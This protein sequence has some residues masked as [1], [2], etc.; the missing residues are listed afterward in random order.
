VGRT[1]LERPE[2]GGTAGLNL[3]ASILGIPGVAGAIQPYATRSV[4]LRL[5]YVRRTENPRKIASSGVGSSEESLGMG[6]HEG[7]VAMCGGS[8]NRGR[9]Q[10]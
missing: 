10:G 2:D 8:K 4:G 7:M 9:Y 1:L 5:L 3:A 6:L